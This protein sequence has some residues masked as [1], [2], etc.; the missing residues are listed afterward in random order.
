MPKQDNPHSAPSPLSLKLIGFLA[1]PSINNRL[2]LGVNCS[3]DGSSYVHSMPSV[4]FIL[5]QYLSN[6]GLPF[7]TLLK[8][9]QFVEHP[10]ELRMFNN[11]M[12][13][14][15]EGCSRQ[16]G[17]ADP[18]VSGGG[19][20]LGELMVAVTQQRQLNDPR[21]QQD[22]HPSRWPTAVPA[23]LPAGCIELPRTAVVYIVLQSD[24]I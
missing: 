8:R 3:E 19:T 12:H 20:S 1:W 7:N 4:N 23:F 10:D 18:D 16:R 2:F 24:Q 5:P 14:S 6:S 9:D 11:H 22:G 21:L 15:E 17:T 13:D